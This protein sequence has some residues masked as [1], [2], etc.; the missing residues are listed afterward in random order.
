M[1]G[2]ETLAEL[3]RIRP[4]IPVAISSGYAELDVLQRFQDPR[5]DGFIQKPYTLESLRIA[6]DQIWPV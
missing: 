3:R 1:D 5:P 2:V 6:L 4:D